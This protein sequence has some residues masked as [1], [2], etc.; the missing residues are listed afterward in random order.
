[1]NGANALTADLRALPSESGNPPNF[2]WGTSVCEL[3]HTYRPLVSVFVSNCWATE[4]SA[5]RAREFFNEEG[6][7]G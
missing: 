2:E 7:N 1:V 4:I 5:L 3:A 6:A